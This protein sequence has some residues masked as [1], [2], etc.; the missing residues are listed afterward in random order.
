MGAR[1]PRLHQRLIAPASRVWDRDALEDLATDHVSVWLAEPSAWTAPEDHGRLLDVLSADE[2]TRAERF[3]FDADRLAFVV[4]HGLLRMALSRHA[5]VTPEAWTF[6]ADSYGKPS[7]ATPAS[8]LGFSLS[9]TRGLVACAVSRSRPLGV[10]VEDASRPAPLEVAERYFVDAERRDILATEPERR[11]RR[12]FE[13]WTLK[14]A[15]VKACGLGLSLPLDRF[16]FRRDA[17]GAWRIAFAPPPLDDPP[18]WWFHAW[19]TPTH[20]AAVA[21]R[22]G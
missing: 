12:F 10:D 17:G 15:F 19:S 22:T 4:A 9:H 18:A 21:L 11:G 2:R 8:T 7:I 1:A 20:Q 5:S 13:Y 6:S 3:H 16:E 14:E